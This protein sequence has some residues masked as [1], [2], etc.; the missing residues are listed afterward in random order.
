MGIKSLNTVLKKHTP[1]CFFTG[2]I[3]M[4]YAKKIA[5]DISLYLF[6]YKACMGLKWLE[7]FINMIICLRNNNVHPIFIFDGKAP[8]EK[9]DEQNK[10]RL[11]SD[12]TKQKAV[13]MEQELLEYLSTGVIGETLL[14]FHRQMNPVVSLLNRPP[15]FE[16]IAPSIKLDIQ[17][18]Q[19]KIAVLKS[20]D[21]YIATADKILIKNLFDI[22]GIQWMEAPDEA[23]RLA[24]RLCVSG[25]VSAVLT[26]D[27]DVLA[28]TTPIMITNLNTYSGGI[29]YIVYSQILEESEL[30]ASAFTDLCIMLGTDYNFNIP[31]YGPVKSYDLIVQYGNIDIIESELKLDVSMLNHLVCRKLFET[32]QDDLET[33]STKFSESN[34]PE[35]VTQLI[36]NEIE[37]NNKLERSIPSVAELPPGLLHKLNLALR[38]VKIKIN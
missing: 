28:Y 27:T 12:M 10:R 14:A 11:Q 38:P 35:N 37:E 6:K 33:W 3:S 31:G 8:V 9:K 2:N 1:S 5:V 34:I 23:E 16:H 25:Q 30:T 15:G 20:Y 17:Q 13:R 22:M 19:D 4:F 36:V 24:A 18:I 32:T 26:E 7:G 21:I 29:E